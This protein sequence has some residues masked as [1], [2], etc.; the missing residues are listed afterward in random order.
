MIDMEVFTSFVIYRYLPLYFFF[1]LACV[2]SSLLLL[3]KSK[4]VKKEPC[5]SAINFSTTT[6]LD[7]KLLF[8]LCLF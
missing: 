3:N 8:S 1:N 2:Q 5:V 6:N 4:K 7:N